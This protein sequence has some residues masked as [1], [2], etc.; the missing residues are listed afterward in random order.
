MK[1]NIVCAG[2][3]MRGIGMVGTLCALEREGY[4]WNRIAGVS[5]GSI[6]AALLAVGY[7]AGEIKKM[8]VDFNFLELK[9]KGI[10]AKIPLLGDMFGLVRH[11]GIYSGT[12]V[13][14]WV[15]TMLKEKG[16]RTFGDLEKIMPGKLK[17]IAA[18]ITL[19][20][21]MVM[22]D[23]LHEYGIEWREFPISK[24]V[25]MSVSIPF[26]FKPVVL[27]VQG[28][29]H[30]IVDGGVAKNF[31]I[32][33]FDHI[34]DGM[35]TIGVDF[36]Y[37]ENFGIK[38]DNTLSYVLDIAD[39]LTADGPRV[40]FEEKNRYRTILI[41]CEDIPITDFQLSDEQILKLF[42]SG[43]RAGRNYVKNN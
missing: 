18:D 21:E 1:K 38:E 27:K 23:C 39:T 5:S 6:I 15:E 17:I 12:R 31:P 37:K 25:R 41:P 20:K 32:D 3:G 11:K 28:V 7:R 4:E 24:A 40:A 34:N 42:R 2:G 9:D 10:M 8:I 26:F 19:K 43:Y 33:I 16:V 36:D 22:P 35:D 13:Q 29:K 30:Y 14:E